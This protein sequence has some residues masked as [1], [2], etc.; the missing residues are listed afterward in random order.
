M[1]NL[2][3]SSELVLRQDT[4]LC[5]HEVYATLRQHKC[6]TLPALPKGRLAAG[7]RGRERLQRTHAWLVPRRLF[8]ELAPSKKRR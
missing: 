6:S 5:M 8:C 4:H 7:S 3:I 1:T 2:N